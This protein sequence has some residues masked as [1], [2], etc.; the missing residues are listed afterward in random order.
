MANNLNLPRRNNTLTTLNNNP[1]TPFKNITTNSNF[2]LGPTEEELERKY[3][4]KQKN[5]EK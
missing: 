4:K 2:R 5:G 1:R 3:N